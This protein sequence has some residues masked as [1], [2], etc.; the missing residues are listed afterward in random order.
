MVIE[1]F[2]MLR[3][4]CVSHGLPQANRIQYAFGGDGTG[5][6]TTPWGVFLYFAICFQ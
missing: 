1:A 2:Q 4:G 5:P 3:P 6:P